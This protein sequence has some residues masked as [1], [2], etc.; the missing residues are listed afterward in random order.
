METLFLYVQAL[1]VTLV[2]PRRWPD[3]IRIGA[4]AIYAFDVL[5]LPISRE[6][7]LSEPQHR[8]TRFCGRQGVR[9]LLL[10]LVLQ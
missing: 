7:H 10:H 2:Q 5:E 1:Y 4:E 6:P 8:I 9:C 3:Q